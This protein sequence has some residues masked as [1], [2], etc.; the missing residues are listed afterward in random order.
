[1]SNTYPDTYQASQTDPERSYGLC[2]HCDN[3]FMRGRSDQRYCGGSC[4]KRAW[5]SRQKQSLRDRI[6]AAIEEVLR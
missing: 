3:V 1:M 4:R 6:V 5:R 2:E